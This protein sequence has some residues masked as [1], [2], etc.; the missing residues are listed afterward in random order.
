MH[1]QTGNRPAGS[2]AGDNEPGLDTSH[3]H[4]ARVYNYW[5]GGK[6]NISQ[7]VPAVPH[8]GPTVTVQARHKNFSKF[9]S[10]TVRG[11][12]G[13][14]LGINVRFVGPGFLTLA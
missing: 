4:P 8:S 5:L 1:R 3:A 11:L 6:D 14:C 10:S 13:P 2:L 9:T 12:S 7:A